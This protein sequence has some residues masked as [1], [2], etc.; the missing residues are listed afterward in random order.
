[1]KKPFRNLALFVSA[2]ILLLFTVFVIN[3]TAQV[4]D[5][6][7]RVAPA[8]GTVVLWALLVFYAL[9]VIMP[10]V[11]FLRLPRSLQPPASEDAPEFP[12][13]LEALKK[14]LAA[15]PRLKGRALADRQQVG[16]AIGFLEHEA[17]DMIQRTASNVFITTAVSQS[18][19]L[20]AFLV[21]S[22]QSRMV[23]QIARLFYQRPT[24]R[25]LM[26]LYANVAATAFVAG[27]I[28][29]L[30]I[31]EQIQPVLSSALG[32]LAGSVPGLQVATS[33]VVSSVLTGTTNAFLTLRVGII[34]K[35]YCGSLVSGQRRTLR[36]AATA[37]AA[38][39]L[40]GVVKQGTARVSRAVWEASKD[41]VGTAATGAKDRV[42][43]AGKNLLSM[44]RI[45]P[46]RKPQ[47]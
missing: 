34:A 33:I 27:E 16:E 47:P 29:D 28:D 46:P 39:L 32:V 19:R 35:R 14:R 12:A 10:A 18:G 5:L 25:E 23:W 45:T 43:D 21:L 26:H 38:K 3:Q 40:T 4:V 7:S 9:L 1:M 2:V 11:L 17:D 30:D 24:P 6:A 44:F 42:K 20:D 15:N 22:A 8:F 36:R 37:E 31:N 13:Y 41:K